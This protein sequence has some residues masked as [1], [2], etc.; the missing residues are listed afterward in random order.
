MSTSV[1]ANGSP[2]AAAAAKP[3]ETTNSIFLFYPNLIGSYSS[4]ES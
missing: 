1:R 3:E 4:R 2:K